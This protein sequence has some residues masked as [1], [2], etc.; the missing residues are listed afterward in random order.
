MSKIFRSTM[1]IFL[2]GLLI[3]AFSARAQGQAKPNVV[4]IL[5]DNVGYGDMGP[6]GGGE[7]RG[8]PTPRTDQLASEG[9]RLTQF[10]VEAACT[11]SRT[12]LMTGQYP[13]RNG[14][15]L[16]ALPGG[17]NTLSA[18]A[19]TMGDL[20]HNAGYATAIFGKWH[21]GEAP[22]SLPGAHGFDEYYGIPPGSSWDGAADIPQIMQTHNAGNAPESY[23]VQNKG[24]WIIQQ[25]GNGPLQKI[26]PFTLEVRAEI[27]N[28]LVDRS[29]EFIKKQTAAGKPFFLYLPFS[30][31]HAPS[32]PSK[33]FAGKSRIGQYGDKIMEGDY[34]VGQILDL[35]KE[36]K[37]ENN[38]IVVFASD[39]GGTGHYFKNWD[40]SGLGAPDMGN[41]GP[42]RGDLGEATEGSIR[43]FAFIRWP[44]H[45][46]PNTTSYAMFSIMDFLPTFAAMIGAKLPTD[47]PFDGV[48]QTDAL[49]GKSETGNREALLTF[50]GP[51]LV[52]ARWHQWRI[53][54]RDMALTGNTEL[55]GGF[56]IN[57]STL[58][59]PK[60]YNI[61]MDPHEE[62]NMVNYLWAA[63]PAFRVIL[64]Y[65]ESLK[66]YPNPPATNLTNFRGNFRQ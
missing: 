42:F 51:D 23:L 24:P 5:A 66:K 12:A 57:S 14:L 6:Y 26:K 33:E 32:L 62:L 13:I 21:L 20:F 22:Q 47:R 64:A 53:Y 40:A 7:L 54:F 31:A 18:S 16:C 25:T 55:L 39:N 50:I 60:I 17:P 2:S 35:L 45:I 8:M 34:H 19:F 9:I 58:Y 38:T 56:A 29:I 52:A 44:G 61:E 49:T 15:S 3:V 10:L 59:Y 36:L 37:I 30:M 63:E 65:E 11:P 41:N 27:D 1:L 4:F 43:T 46:K 28:E 48:D